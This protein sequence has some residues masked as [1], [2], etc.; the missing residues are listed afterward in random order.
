MQ[1]NYNGPGL[2]PDA[3]DRAAAAETIEYEC[4][5]L[6]A[7]A[8]ASGFNFLAYLIDVAE[9]EAAAQLTDLKRPSKR[10]PFG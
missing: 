3:S 6:K 4:R 1:R 5:R 10:S 9:E 2:R 7:I 8:E